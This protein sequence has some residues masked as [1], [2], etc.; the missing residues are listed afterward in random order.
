MF[1]NALIAALATSTFALAA[2]TP[3]RRHYD[4]LDDP[5]L[6]Y[7]WF[8]G[9]HGARNGEF[10][11]KDGAAWH[12]VETG[13]TGNIVTLHSKADYD[14]L[15]EKPYIG[16]VGA[17]AGINFDGLGIPYMEDFTSAEQFKQAAEIPSGGHSKPQISCIIKFCKNDGPN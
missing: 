8:N 6:T 17:P 16:L 5:A 1:F 13:L 12:A 14:A 15:P 3:V 10:I 4:Q 9:T 11:V 2:S 7:Y